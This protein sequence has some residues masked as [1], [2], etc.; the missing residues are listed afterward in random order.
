MLAIG[1]GSVVAL[2]IAATTTLYEHTAR[3]DHAESDE[4]SGPGASPAASRY[5]DRRRAESSP[6][7]WP[8][9]RTFHRRQAPAERSEDGPPTPQQRQEALSRRRAEVETFVEHHQK[10]PV[11]GDWQAQWEGQIGD[12]LHALS[13][14]L[15]F[16][17]DL[18][19]RSQTCVATVQWPSLS[20][21]RQGS[22]RILHDSAP[23]CRTEV[24]IDPAKITGESAALVEHQVLYSRCASPEPGARGG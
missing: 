10:E 19:C 22:T 3:R 18:S 2:T 14:E 5:S 9:R 24:F 20:D 16:V 11:D 12:R 13:D 6:A 23:Y 15:G 1:G 17:S 8:A 21:A 7:R 4:R